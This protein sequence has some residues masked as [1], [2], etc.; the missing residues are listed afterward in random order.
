MKTKRTYTTPASETL[1]VKPQGML[2]E[3]SQ[4][5]LFL[6]LMNGTGD[7]D[8]ENRTSGGTWGDDGIWY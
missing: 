8:L 5:I 4:A 3:S 6:G 7:K 2:C 1:E